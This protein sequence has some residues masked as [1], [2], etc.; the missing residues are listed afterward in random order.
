[1]LIHLPIT[2]AFDAAGHWPRDDRNAIT[3]IA[4]T[5]RFDPDDH[6]IPVEVCNCYPPPPNAEWA[7]AEAILYPI[8]RHSYQ[9]LLRRIE[10]SPIDYCADEAEGLRLQDELDDR[11]GCGR[12]A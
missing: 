7:V 5:V 10:R 4:L 9:R 11:L 6:S 1:M 2:I 12:V 8:D 3:K